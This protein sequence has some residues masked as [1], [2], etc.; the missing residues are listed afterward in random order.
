[1]QL[2]GTHMLYWLLSYLLDW[3]L[4]CYVIVKIINMDF[5]NMETCHYLTLLIFTVNIYLRL[6]I[7]YFEER[8]Y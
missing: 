4:P 6:A 5:S 3:V 7:I 8:K 2:N 1:M